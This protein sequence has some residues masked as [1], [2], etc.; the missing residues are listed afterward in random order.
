M[1]AWV[2]WALVAGAG[3]D[4]IDL[5]VELQAPEACPPR[6]RFEAELRARSEKLRIVDAPTAQAAT[7]SLNITQEK[8]RFVGTSKVKTAMSGV[9]QRQFKSAQCET[10]IQAAALATSLLLDPE[11]TKTGEVTVS[12][13]PRPVEPVD[14]GSPEPVVVVVDAGVPLVEPVDAGA[15]PVVV[16]EPVD[17]GAPAS[18]PVQLELALGGGVT[19]AI[20]GAIDPELQVSVALQWPRFRL[21]LSPRYIVGRRVSS[22]NGVAQYFAAGGRLDGL[23]SVPLGTV[24]RIEGGAQLSV[25]MVPVTGPEAEVPGRALGVLVA[26]GPFARVVVLVGSLR[27]ALEGGLGVNLRAER[28]L[29]DGAG[30]VFTAPRLFGTVGLS[31]GWSF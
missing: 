12:L 13:E 21:A 30:L 14:A 16:A 20:S 1:T 27:L 11:G 28:Y 4:R 24:L 3:G 29:I 19:T 6:A 22:A 10:L 9:T 18:S 8:K 15:P 17:A 25:L 2:L 31:V 26:P 5:L 7:V 23:F